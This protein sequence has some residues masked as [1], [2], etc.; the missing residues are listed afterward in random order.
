MDTSV[1]KNVEEIE[2]SERV[3]TMTAGETVPSDD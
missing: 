3:T 2:I 1:M